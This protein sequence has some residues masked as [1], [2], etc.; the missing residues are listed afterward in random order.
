MVLEIE[1]E[2]YPGT[3]QPAV[4]VWIDWTSAPGTYFGATG[5][6]T[7][8]AY[9][10]ANGYS[11]VLLYGHGGTPPPMTMHY[12]G[13]WFGLW[14]IN[15][16]V[17]NASEHCSLSPRAVSVLPELGNTVTVTKSGDCSGRV[18]VI[19][20]VDG[21]GTAGFKGGS[22]CGLTWVNVGLILKVQ[23]CDEGTLRLR[24]YT[25]STLALVDDEI[26]ITVELP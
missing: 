13:A 26:P 14:L 1:L 16:P 24:V 19:Q 25:D 10:D 20:Q 8:R 15:N 21:N 9:T 22:Q 4:N 12:Q 18:A 6:N 17:Y 11:S 23:G 2:E 3:G 5:T 7:V